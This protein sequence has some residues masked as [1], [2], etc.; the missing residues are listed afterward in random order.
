MKDKVGTL[1]KTLV[2]KGK[3]RSSEFEPVD[4][5]A[6]QQYNARQEAKGLRLLQALDKQQ[7]EQI[8]VKWVQTAAKMISEAAIIGTQQGDKKA[9]TSAEKKIRENLVEKLV[10]AVEAHPAVGRGTLPLTG[11]ELEDKLSETEFPTEDVPLEIR[12]DSLKLPGLPAPIPS[13]NVRMFIDEQG[14]FLG[15]QKTDEEWETQVRWLMLRQSEERLTRDELGLCA[16]KK[17]KHVT[18]RREQFIRVQER[19]V[20][21]MK[22][23]VTVYKILEWAVA[24]DTGAP[25]LVQELKVNTVLQ[26]GISRAN[27]ERIFAEGWLHRL[28]KDKKPRS[29]PLRGTFPKE[30]KNRKNILA[31]Q[32]LEQDDFEQE[33]RLDPNGPAA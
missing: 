3:Q 33:D 9:Q 16:S 22:D 17:Y 23:Q 12:L 26:E 19:F 18:S 20:K 6:R 14:H 25:T 31:M 5:A 21:Q 7:K 32:T 30:S 11:Q 15:D 1:A 27:A 28:D 13:L 10:S 2:E 8:A 4:E 24:L 29:S